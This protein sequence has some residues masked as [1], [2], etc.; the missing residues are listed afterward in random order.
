ML[1]SRAGAAAVPAPCRKRGRI[2]RSQMWPRVPTSRAGVA[3]EL[4]SR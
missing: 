4:C 1:G 3:G 2:R